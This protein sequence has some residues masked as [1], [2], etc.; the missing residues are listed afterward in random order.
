MRLRCV[1]QSSPSSTFSMASQVRF[2][3]AALL[4]A[5][6]EM[7][8]VEAAH[9]RRE[10]RRDMDAVGDVADGHGVFRTAG[11]E[12][13]PHG[14][15]D[16]AVQRGDGIDAARELEA[17]DGHA[18]R[19]AVIGGMF[20]AEA[21]EVFVR[22]AELVAQGAEVLFDEVGA[23]SDHGRRGRACGW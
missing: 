19:L 2:G 8:I 20:A 3:A 4:P 7:A 22:D 5:D 21:H 9:L 10:P 18:E 11:I 23:G 17:E 12:A 13:L 1:S 16:F 15:R 14:A 6:A